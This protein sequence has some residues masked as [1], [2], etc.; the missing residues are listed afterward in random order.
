MT[1]R[2]L[3]IAMVTEAMKYN[4]YVSSLLKTSIQ[5]EEMRQTGCSTVKQ[6]TESKKGVSGP[7]QFPSHPTFSVYYKSKEK[8]V[9]NNILAQ[10]PRTGPGERRYW[11]MLFKP[12][13][14]P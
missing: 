9:G 12:P 13:T 8:E 6:H 5:E 4:V 1:P 3:L 14:G 10:N 2:I 7:N 11:T